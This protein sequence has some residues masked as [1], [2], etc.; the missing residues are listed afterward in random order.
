[1]PDRTFVDA[2][3]T[4]K[5]TFAIAGVFAVKETRQVIAGTGLSGGGDLS[6]NRTIALAASGVTP[7]TYGDGAN[8]P[9]VVVDAYGRVTSVS[10]LPAT[11]GGSLNSPG[12]G[13][14]ALQSVNDVVS[15]DD[16]FVTGTASDSAAPG[17]VNIVN[18]TSDHLIHFRGLVAGANVTLTANGNDI[19]IASTGG[20]GGS[21]TDTQAEAAA[22]RRMI[23]VYSAAAPGAGHNLLISAPNDGLIAMGS[24]TAGAWSVYDTITGTFTSGTFTGAAVAAYTWAIYVSGPDLIWAGNGS[25]THAI[26]PTTKVATDI[27]AD[28]GVLK[29]ANYNA[30]ANKVYGFSAGTNI[31]K[32][33]H[34]S[35]GVVSRTYA[36]SGQTGYEL[37]SHDP[38]N[39]DIVLLTLTASGGGSG[40]VW[41]VVPYVAFDAVSLSQS[42]GYNGTYHVDDRITVDP[43]TRLAYAVRWGSGIVHC[44][45]LSDGTYRS[46]DPAMVVGGAYAVYHA[47]TQRVYLGGANR[48]WLFRIDP[49]SN[50]AVDVEAANALHSA[51]GAHTLVSH[52]DGFLYSLSG[53]FMHKIRP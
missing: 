41:K 28:T 51:L 34:P 50:A 22:A 20:G 31:V 12:A 17:A 23:I 44:L 43:N 18:G 2:V 13:R 46:N 35:T 8:V 40:N 26:D 38:T 16:N 11:P 5:S 19:T 33:M 53:L 45:K 21:Y 36:I 10:T 47:A 29:N 24:V 6:A 30:V 49:T 4:L 37:I 9:V 32:E 3:G 52:T 42:T 14:F 48:L 15:W 7:G 1:M 39:G 25:V 27:T